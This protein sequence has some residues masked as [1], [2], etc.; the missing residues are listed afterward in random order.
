ME[1]FFVTR[2]AFKIFDRD[3]DGFIDMKEFRQV[4]KMICSFQKADRG[5]IDSRTVGPGQRRG[6][7]YRH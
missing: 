7:V 4:T 2:E 6:E 5:N 1:R 3:G